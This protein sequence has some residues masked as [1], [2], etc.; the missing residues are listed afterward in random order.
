MK[1]INYNSFLEKIEDTKLNNYDC[2]ILLFY[3]GD[4]MMYEDDL[5]IEDEDNFNIIFGDF[6]YYIETEGC[7]DKNFRSIIDNLI[8]ISR[9]RKLDKVDIN[10]T[11]YKEDVLKFV[12]KINN[13]KITEKVFEGQLYKI[14]KINDFQYLKNQLSIR[15]G[16]MMA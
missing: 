4:I 5:E 12:E 1:I 14:F 10:Y 7:N 2:S 16:L 3:T 11:L 13:N 6:I 9:I 15:F 8:S